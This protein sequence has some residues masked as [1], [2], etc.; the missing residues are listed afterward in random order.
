[1]LAL[2]S[3]FKDLMMNMFQIFQINYNFHLV[4]SVLGVCER[5]PLRTT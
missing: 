3:V 1:M 4:F 2:R 5:D